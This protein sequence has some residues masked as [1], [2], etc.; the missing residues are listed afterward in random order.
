M[1]TV[2]LRLLLLEDNRYD[3]ELAIATLEE[4]G[5]ECRWERVETEDEFVARLA[6]AGTEYDLILA[7]YSLPA[8]D[9][10][11]ALRKF[12]ERELDIPFILV[13]GT[14]GEEI[15]IESLRAGATDYV[16]KDRI[17]RLAPVV[18]RALRERDERR[19]RRR[20]QE[21]VRSSEARW[22]SLTENSADRIMTLD[23]DL[24]VEFANR[25]PPGLRVDEFIGSRFYQWSPEERRL[26]IKGML[27][28][29]LRTGEPGRFRLKREMPD[30]RSVH[31]ESRVATRIVRD[32]V[33]GL[34]V[35][36]RDITDR[37]EAEREREALMA[38]VGAHA[39]RV[40]QIIN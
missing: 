8:F 3:A 2:A 34:T 40:Q 13:S 30:G 6:R 29:V 19:E 24:K 36:S 20:A 4:A 28:R 18:K 9:G 22:R 32:E 38:E 10:L 15:A 5:Y 26:E 39:V 35:S 27:E 37:V 21:A 31:Y 14:L 11:T 12:V 7:D 17:S 25:P 1:M 23:R 16:L 33:V